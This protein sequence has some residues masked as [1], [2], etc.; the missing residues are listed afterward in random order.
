M[1]SNNNN[2]LDKNMSLQG[3]K[4]TIKCWPRIFKILWEIDRAKVLVIT[5]TTIILGALPAII[6]VITQNLVNSVIY[7]ENGNFSII[8][9]NFVILVLLS[10]TT[11][12][13]TAIQ[14]YSQG[15][16]QTKL[17]YKL[18]IKLMKKAICL[19]LTDF[20]NSDIYDKFQRAQNE[21]G[22]RPYQIYSSILSVLGSSI[23]L[24]SASII[25]ILWK[26]WIVL[27]LLIVP[28]ISTIYSVK[29]GKREYIIQWKRAPR[30]R[31][32]WYYVY[33]VSR[34]INYKEVKLYGTG[35]YLLNKYSKIFDRYLK[36][37]K[38]ILKIRNII[39]FVFNLLMNVMGDAI[40][41]LIL[42]SAFI[43]EIAFGNLLSYI[44]AVSMTESN[45][46]G[47]LSTVF[48]MYQDTL[49]IQQLFEFLDLDESEPIEYNED[50]IKDKKTLET[51]EKIEFRNVS[52]K[53]PN[54][55]EYAL[56]YINFI[57]E[58]GD[59]I[60]VVGENGSG[61][62]TMVKLLTRLYEV[63]DG[64]I[65][66]NNIN[67]NDYNLESLR[68]TFGIVFQD[69][70]KYELKVRHNIGFGDIDN[71]EDDN[72]LMESAS[73]AGVSNLIDKMPYKLETQLGLWFS[74]GQQLSG[75][76]WQKIAIARA[77]FRK[78]SVY[79]LDEPSSSLDPIAEK[80]IFEQFFNAVENKIGIFTSHRFSTVKFAKTILVFDGGY[81]IE[82]GTHDELIE[83][84]GHYKK[85]YEI[86]ASPFNVNSVK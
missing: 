49:Y 40:T 22:Y 61:K 54:S 74:Q 51:I 72:S 82:E 71:I 50:E 30:F 20:E 17:G 10:V 78:A 9:G 3:V 37:D 48:S 38:K 21:V 58:K 29:I 73:K 41:L 14:N 45:F 19:S 68:K 47:I 83:F 81:V 18:N 67:I 36:T 15:I 1:S 65:L 69:F 64:E 85:L 55:K 23:T 8:I 43:R 11:E 32:A 6:L 79:I 26:W 12:T 84:G 25:L 53:Y 7:N 13:V 42:Y 59:I 4:E 31:K 34:D 60:A 35:K 27:A 70:V 75:G 46:Q 66:I 33:L 56:R 39:T 80:E 63:D 57:L 52:F 5:F 77:F 24:I 62:T 86:Q 76:Q 28:V 44:R 16:F 2:N